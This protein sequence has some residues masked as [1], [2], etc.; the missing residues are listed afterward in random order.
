MTVPAFEHRITARCRE[1]FQN[2]KVVHSSFFDSV[3]TAV[4][5]L[6]MLGISPI[7]TLS[8]EHD[9]ACVQV[10]SHRFAPVHVGDDNEFNIQTVVSIAQQNVHDEDFHIV[11]IHRRR[12]WWS[13]VDYQTV[14]QHLEPSTPWSLQWSTEDGWGRL[15]NP[16]ARE[17][18]LSLQF[19]DLPLPA[20][21]QVSPSYDTCTD[22][23][24]TFTTSK[25]VQDR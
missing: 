21:I 17:M 19:K 14:T 16:I 12:L 6:R 23:G 4:A 22:R 13:N 10:L 7:L 18:Q 11:I 3:G 15:S 20:I 8:W 2:V 5:A 25:E 24:R 9:E 1:M